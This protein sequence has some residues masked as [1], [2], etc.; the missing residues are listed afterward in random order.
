MKKSKRID[1]WNYK[2]NNVLK[3]SNK[4]I[5]STEYKGLTFAF[6]SNKNRIELPDDSKIITKRLRWRK[7]LFN[8]KA[9]YRDFNAYIIRYNNYL[10]MPSDRWLD[11]YNRL[12]ERFYYF[13]TRNIY[14]VMYSF[15]LFLAN[16]S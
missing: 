6:E 8:L 14:Y 15:G 16:V 7:K 4:V 9:L 2:W 11:D 13:N 12:Y 3:N 5:C 1:K 10:Y